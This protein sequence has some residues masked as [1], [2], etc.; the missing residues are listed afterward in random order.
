MVYDVEDKH[1]QCRWFDA[2]TNCFDGLV[3]SHTRYIWF[4][5]GTTIDTIEQCKVVVFAAGYTDAKAIGSTFKWHVMSRG[6][7]D[8]D[9]YGFQT[10][11]FVT[12][13]E[14][15]LDAVR[16]LKGEKGKVIDYPL[17]QHKT[18]ITNE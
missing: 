14:A 12:E 9:D 2:E 17:F 4:E 1:W 18:I 5:R 11:T 8:T 3:S 6:T 16:I 7:K 15:W 13:A 10:N